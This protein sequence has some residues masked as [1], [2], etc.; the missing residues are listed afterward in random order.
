MVDLAESIKNAL[1]T[2][3]LASQGI[4]GLFGGRKRRT[5]GTLSW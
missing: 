2:S 3:P 4:G 5:T 1:L